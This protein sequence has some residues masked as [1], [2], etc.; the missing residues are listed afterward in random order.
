MFKC[1]S[2]YCQI[3]QN[4]SSSLSLYRLYNQ[5]FWNCLLQFHFPRIFR[6][7]ADSDR[8]FYA[9]RLHNMCLETLQQKQYGIYSRC[10]GQIRSRKWDHSF[11]NRKLDGFHCVDGRLA[12]GLLKKEWFILLVME[13][14]IVSSGPRVVGIPSNELVAWGFYQGQCILVVIAKGIKNRSL[15][16]MCL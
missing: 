11:C 2:I 15:K 10:R 8:S 6:P 3:N 7:A 13:K 4:S 12:W 5:Q 16:I 14:G 9:E 1:I